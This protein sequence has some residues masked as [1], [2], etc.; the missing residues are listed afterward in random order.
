MCFRH[1]MFPLHKIFVFYLFHGNGMVL[2]RFLRLAGRKQY[3]V[4]MNHC[5]AH[6]VNTV[7]TD[8]A[9]IELRTHHIRRDISIFYGIT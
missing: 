8:R 9:H 6:G 4:A 5:L 7:S 3:S 1:I 2:I